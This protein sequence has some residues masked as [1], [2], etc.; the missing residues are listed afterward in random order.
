MLL[1][2]GALIRGVQPCTCSQ[3]S[4]GG[5]GGGGGRKV[6]PPLSQRDCPHILPD[7][8]LCNPPRFLV[9]AV[10]PPLVK[11]S[12]INPGVQRAIIVSKYTD[13]QVYCEEHTIV[14]CIYLCIE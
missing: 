7:V 12:E 5:G 1:F 2:Q 11:L 6:L 14:T 3:D 4:F 13:D 8:F 10:R 9:C